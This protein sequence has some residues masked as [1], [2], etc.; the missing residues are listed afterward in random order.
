MT[1][2]RPAETAAQTVLVV[3]DDPIICAALSAGLEARGRHLI[4]CRDF[5]SAKLIL[6]LYPVTHVLS[7]VK[8][9]GPFRFEGL[10]VLD[11]VKRSFPAA[12]VMLMTGYASEELRRE[13]RAHGAEAVLEK[14]VSLDEIERFVPLPDRDTESLVTVV[15]TLDDVLDNGMLMTQFQP[16][17][18]I[19][20]PI[21][22]V[23]FEALTRVRTSSPLSNPELLFRYA[24]AIGRVT[25]LEL[26]AAGASMLAGRE[27][28]DIG[29]ISINVHP[30][31]FSEV[32]R[33]CNGVLDAAAE[34]G[35]PPTRL[36]LEITEQGPLPD[37]GQVEAVA[38]ILRAH[39]VRFA[40]D[41]V[42]SGY[43]HVQALT[44]VRPSYLKISQQFGTSCESNEAHR[45]IIRNV[46][47]LARAFSSEILLEGI[48]TART[49]TFAREAG[50]TL[51]QGYL[52]CRP[53]EVAALVGRYA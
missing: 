48:E 34:A 43:S 4:V 47:D 51:G 18:W 5:E 53:T 7:D 6:G 17:V 44:A 28:T 25:D 20:K 41:D 19:D 39:G 26:A 10:D 1:I 31:V 11:F 52:F 15:P 46:Q 27:L 33:L 12:L 16:M 50:I 36:V 32:D 21:H 38:G 2:G 14:P 49:A 23:G 40:F 22:A 45:K 8:F 42:G 35:V 37:L 29:F 3:D 9:T 30:I 13:A 24:A